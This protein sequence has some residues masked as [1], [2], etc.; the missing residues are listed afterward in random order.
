MPQSLVMYSLQTYSM[1]RHL[2][3]PSSGTIPKI[4]NHLNFT[5]MLKGNAHVFHPVVLSKTPSQPRFHDRWGMQFGDWIDPFNIGIVS[6]TS[7]QAT[8]SRSHANDPAGCSNTKK[9]L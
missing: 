2:N 7:S 1:Y 8:L 5:A 6:P 3:F 9:R 4:Q